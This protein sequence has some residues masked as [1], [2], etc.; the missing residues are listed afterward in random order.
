MHDHWHLITPEYPPAIGGVADYTRLAAER[1]RREGKTVSVWHPGVA[2]L[3][4]GYTPS[5][6]R[7]LHQEIDQAPGRRRLFVQWVPH[8]YGYRSMNVAFAA[9]LGSRAR[10]GDEIDLMVHEPFLMFREGTI[11]QDAAAVVH[12]LMM[13]L[14]LAAA[15]RV[16]ITIPQWHARLQPWYWGR[17]IPERWLPVPS[18]IEVATAGPANLEALFPNPGPVVG[19]FG[20]N[21]KH[22]VEMLQRLLP[23]VLASTPANILLLGNG[24]DRVAR[25]FGNPRVQGL[26]RQENADISR[27]IQACTMMLQPYTDGVSTRRSSAM[28]AL[29]HGKALAS[30][31]GPAT[32]DI[33]QR[34]DIACLRAAQDSEGLVR[35]VRELLDNQ[36]RRHAFGQRALAAYQQHF[37]IEQTIRQLIEAGGEPRG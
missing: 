2:P 12:R 26:G 9:W 22:I 34:E 14:A 5:G 21:G 10:R 7:R 33:W 1:L 18:N 4:E 6:L 27:S 28:A 31:S 35:C 8:G 36:E 19:H 32:E 15:A 25:E 37:S 16:W 3:E 23:G 29:I 13:S 20:T 24:S 17:R 30:T 11:K